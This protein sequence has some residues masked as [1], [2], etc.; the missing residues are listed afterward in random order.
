MKYAQNLTKLIGN[1]PMVRL[2][3][4]TNHEDATIFA[5]LESYNPGGSIKDRI[6]YAMVLD[7]EERGLLRPGDTIVEPTAGNTGIGLSIVGVARGYKVI[8]TM[9]ENVSSEK[10]ALLSAF[11]ANI[12]LTPE[13][14]GM[15]SAIWEAEEIL[16][17]NPRHFMPNQFT[18][19]A[20]PQIHRQTT[21]VE[22]LKAMGENIDAFVAGV[23]TGGTLTGVGE[24]LKT[25]NPN[26]K[27]VA[28][29]PLVS[30]VLSGGQPGPTR[31]DG[32]GA[33]MVPEVLNV[34]IIDD[35]IAVSEEVAY[36]T[37]KDISKKE[38]LLVG[39]SSG[40]NV[41]AALKIAKALGR[42]KTVVT[43]LPDTG[44][45]YFSLSRH[46]ELETDILETLP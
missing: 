42:G 16:R 15:A 31:I 41:H 19:R 36:Q 39:M 26:T 40:A 9:P 18:N 29:E 37:M 33:G 21:A 12:V 45:R 10:Y 2:N 46:F 44:E 28:V 11:G 25:R 32:L 14:G 24:M 38:G 17:R 22:I 13:H 7:A 3:A 43:I 27:V 34:E 5:K 6:S 4:L 23:G 35:V 8:L 30:A 1:T 20:N